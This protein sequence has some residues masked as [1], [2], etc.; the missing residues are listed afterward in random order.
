LDILP[1]EEVEK[2]FGAGR[3]NYGIRGR[4]ILKAASDSHEP[5][6]K[7]NT[8][9]ETLQDLFVLKIKS[10]YDVET[11]LVKALPKMVKK[12]SDPKVKSGF[13]GHLKETKGQVKRLEKVF[14]ILGLKPQKI[15]V[16][17]ISGIIKDAEW[18]MK[19]IKDKHALDSAIIA[20]AS[21]V[22]HYETAGYISASQWAGLLGLDNAE[23]L[24]KETLKEEEG[25]AEELNNLATSKIDRL[26]A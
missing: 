12:S 6:M 26:A 23:Q 10:L 3:Q 14:S 18:V 22:E 21:Y 13:E 19:N 1:S 15:Q 24:L 4:N 11:K 16:E 2:I 7:N 8:D 20:A 5:P 9:Y 17:G 25:G